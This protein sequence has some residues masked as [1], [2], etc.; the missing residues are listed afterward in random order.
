MKN[1][2]FIAAGGTFGALSR[3]YLSRFIHQISGSMFPWGTLLINLSGSFFIGFFFELFDSYVIPAP[4]RNFITVGFLGA[5]TTFSTYSLET[6]NLLREGEMKA[7]LI[8]LIASNVLGI[9]LVVAGIYTSRMILK[10]I[11]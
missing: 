10:L 1:A 11:K 3:Y 6:V 2:L 5:Y 9:I 8:N 7:G 4:I